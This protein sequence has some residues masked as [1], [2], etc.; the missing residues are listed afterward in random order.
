MYRRVKRIP[1]VPL[2]RDIDQ[3][4]GGFHNSKYGA[5][6]QLLKE[7]GFRPVEASRLNPKSFDLIK[8]TVTL[9][10]PAKCSNPRQMR[11]SSKLVNMITPL[12]PDK[13][14][15]KLIWDANIKYISD[16][17][18]KKRNT[19]FRQLGN[20]RLKQITL[21]SFRH[22]KGSTEYAKTKDI[23]H[24]KNVLEHVNIQNTMIYIHILGE[25]P[26]ENYI[27]KVAQTIDARAD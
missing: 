15:N 18:R 13:Q 10:D 25:E 5:Y 21:K 26:D 20:P 19:L 1:H 23:F 7:T 8:R 12:I 24:V 6:L 14:S 9:N 4:I 3:L 11:I 2:E 27:V 22:F 16:S 17:Y